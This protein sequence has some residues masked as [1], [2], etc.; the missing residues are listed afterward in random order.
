MKSKALITDVRWNGRKVLLAKPQT[1]MNLSGEAIGPLVRF[2]QIPLARLIVVYDDLDL[3]HGALRMR[4][5]GGSGGHKGLQS[6]I[7]HVGGQGFPR[8]RIGIG[9]P[10][11]RMDPADYVLQDFS[12]DEREAME[13]TLREALQCLRDLFAE[14]LAIAMT[15][16]NDD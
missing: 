11:G 9:R 3:P 1:L 13:I 15:R 8:L 4:P 16:C 12:Q 2:Y 14:G 5:S 7:E 6:V 10:P